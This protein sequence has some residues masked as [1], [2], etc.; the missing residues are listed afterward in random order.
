MQL[1]ICTEQYSICT[2]WCSICRVQCSICTLQCSI[3]E[4]M[5][6]IVQYMYSITV[7]VVY[8]EVYVEDSVVDIEYSTVD[9]TC[10]GQHSR[11]RVQHSRQ[12]MQR[13]LQYM[14]NYTLHV[15]Y[16]TTVFVHNMYTLFTLKIEPFLPQTPRQQVCQ[17]STPQ[18]TALHLLLELEVKGH[19][20]HPNWSKSPCMKVRVHQLMR[21]NITNRQIKLNIRFIQ[22]I[23]VL[24]IS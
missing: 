13:I 5:Y 14:L 19:P 15:L 3:I 1:S 20:I 11:Y 6:S 24:L 7:D 12:Q 18:T 22:G 2:V 8:S 16:C 4:C 21:Q 10:R 17:S 9:S 23:P